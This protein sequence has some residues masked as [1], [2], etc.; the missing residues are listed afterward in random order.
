MPQLMQLQEGLSS[1]GLITSVREHPHLWNKAFT[2]S[3]SCS[4]DVTAEDFMDQLVANFSMSQIQKEKE[5][6]VYKLFCDF[7]RA[8]DQG[9]GGILGIFF[10]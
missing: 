7:L 6:E 9:K 8:I 10:A 4:E 2:L 1:C 5:I 3:N